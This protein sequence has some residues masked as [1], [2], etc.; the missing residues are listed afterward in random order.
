V[1]GSTTR[2]Q[3][4]RFRLCEVDAAPLSQLELA[5]LKAKQR[6]GSAVQRVRTEWRAPS[7]NLRDAIRW[8]QI[9]LVG[10]VRMWQAALPTL[11]RNDFAFTLALW[12]AV[13][14]VAA[15]VVAAPGVPLSIRYTAGLAAV[16]YL[17]LYVELARIAR[18][19]PGRS[20]LLGIADL[21]VV[22]AI[23]A[24]SV[25]YVPYARV[26][27]FFAAART[28]ARWRDPRILVAGLLM[29]VPFELAGHAVPLT[30]LFDAFLVLMTMVLV[31][32]LM[33]GLDA[34][35]R[36]VQRQSV[37]ASLIS[38]LAR[39]RDEEALF[40]QL[41]TQA[42]ALAPTCAWAF[43][44]MDPS[45][46]EYRAVRWAGLPE[47]EMP[48]FSFTPTLTAEPGQP[49]LIQ[50]PLPGTSAGT[51]TLIQPTTG[52]GDPNGL[53][54]VGGRPSD[55]DPTVRGL[56]RSVG[57]EMGAT[58]LRLQTL[59]DQRQRTEAMEQAN[60]LAGL[61]AQH[62][63]D[64]PA[65]LSAIRPALASLLRSESL[66]LEWVQGDRLSLVVGPNDPLEAHAPRWLSLAGTRT[67]EAL[68]QGRALREPLTGRRPEDLFGVPAGLRQ[69]AVAPLHCAGVDGT[70]QLARRL[71][72]PYAAGELMLLQLLAER[73]GLLFAAGRTPIPARNL[74]DQGVTA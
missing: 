8:T 74:D 31:V 14:S 50:G 11:L 35:Q 39:V 25:P 65:A 61:A 9:A 53:V 23:G 2:P 43:W 38:G 15:S 3:R 5:R 58:L 18:P 60:R 20:L 34:A 7:F 42:P 62:A 33:G 52:D 44:I 46:D 1:A 55:F 19:V 72:R 48:G 49:V 54:T 71:P 12:V 32:H 24:L 63:L 68:L 22:C 13:F 21:A 67:A 41:A 64:Q 4:F 51:C 28:A 16:A 10:E 6:A 26:L 59:D 73:L 27:L 17:Y 56:I 70:L 40:A 57:D 29:L 69:I 45:G 47:G 66:H 36:T 37:L 30:M